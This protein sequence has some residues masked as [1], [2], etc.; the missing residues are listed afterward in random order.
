M[1]A[2]Q[3]AAAIAATP[4]A[5]GTGTCG[6]LH[7]G[8]FAIDF[9]CARSQCSAAPGGPAMCAPHFSAVHTAPAASPAFSITPSP[10]SYHKRT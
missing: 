10:T 3:P 7:P 9:A 8:L 1:Q 6:S 4:I 2:A 5:V